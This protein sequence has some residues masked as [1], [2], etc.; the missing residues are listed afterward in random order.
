M[1]RPTRA[2]QRTGK[3]VTPFAC[4]DDGAD[5]GTVPA[6]DAGLAVAVQPLSG[7]ADGV[8]LIRRD[9]EVVGQEHLALPRRGGLV[10]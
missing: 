9:D 6:H 8:A 1:F 5:H 2:I 3:N 7:R 10:V 4:S